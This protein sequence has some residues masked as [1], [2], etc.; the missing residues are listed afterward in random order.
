M[1]RRISR[2]E[3]ASERARPRPTIQFS[4]A[5]NDLIFG[6]FCFY[7]LFDAV[8]WL[9]LF[10]FDFSFAFRINLTSFQFGMVCLC[11]CA[12]LTATATATTDERRH[13]RTR[14]VSFYFTWTSSSVKE[15]SA[16]IRIE[17]IFQYFFHLCRTFTIIYFIVFSA[18]SFRPCLVPNSYAR[19]ILNTFLWHKSVCMSHF[20]L[21]SNACLFV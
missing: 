6:L 20:S 3:N 5:A 19:C 17:V 13:T 15:W 18:V 7:F 21:A 4:C 1:R 11:V 10:L 8:R 12:F 16:S 2:V 14:C 9:L